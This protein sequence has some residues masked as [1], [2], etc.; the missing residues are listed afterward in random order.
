V[1]FFRQFDDFDDDALMC[2]AK[3]LNV[4]E[5]DFGVN[6]A[7]QLLQFK[8]GHSDSKRSSDGPFLLR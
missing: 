8:S 6:V 4:L 2:A 3:R 1:P 7:P 5:Q